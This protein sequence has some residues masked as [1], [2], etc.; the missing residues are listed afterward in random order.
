MIQVNT[1]YGSD[2]EPRIAKFR[3]KLKKVGKNH[4]T[5]QIQTK[6]N[7][8]QFYNQFSSVA[9]LCLTLRPHERQKARHPGL[10][11]WVSSSHQA[12]K[13]LEF[14]LQYQLF[15]WTP[16]RWCPLGWTGWISLQS[17]GFKSLLQHH[18]SI[19]SILQCSV[20]FMVQHS[21]L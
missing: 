16:F 12:A 9:Q 17:K 19:A 2:H 3:F 13:V 8:L 18:S 4:Q 5:I 10:F 11:K 21:H 15:Q 20:F 6:S 7:P 1:K 14:Q